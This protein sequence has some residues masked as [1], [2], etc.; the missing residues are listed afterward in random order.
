[1]KA[2]KAA[3]GASGVVLACAST[4]V[5]ALGFDL[6]DGDVTGH[7][8]TTAS[9]GAA[10]RMESQSK[11]LI[12]KG[13]MS[14][15]GCSGAYQTCQGL[16]RDQVYPS[17]Q[18]GRLPGAYAMRGDDGDL[19]Y[20]KHDLTQAVAKVT[21]DLTLNWGDF[22]F[23]GRW[24]YYYDFVNNDFDETHPNI[25]TPENV[26]RVGITGDPISNRYFSHVYGPG[27]REKLKRND[28]SSLRSIGTAFQ[29]LDANI[30][31]HVAIPFWE[32]HDL[33]F[34]IGRQTVNWGESTLLAINSINQANPVNANNLYRVGTQVEEVFTPV[35]MVFASIEPFTN[36]T[37]EAFYQFQWEPLD[38]PPPGSYFATN[39]LGTNNAGHSV[40][41]SFGSAPDDPE[42]AFDG[43]TAN[44]RKG[45]LDNPLTLITP[46]TGTLYRER[47]W[48]A[49]NQ[50]QFGIAMK[51]YAENLGSGTEFGAYF[52]NYH[53]K[54]PYISFFAAPTACSHNANVKNTTSFFAACG[55]IPAVADA[56]ARSQLGKDSIPLLTSNLLNPTL[57]RETGAL[58]VPD[59]LTTLN[60]LLISGGDPNA[61]LDDSAELDNPR[62]VFEYPENIH[63]FGLSF[64]TSIG[65][66]SI[67]GEVAYRPN[68]PLQISIA[69][70]GFAALGPTLQSCGNYV[71]GGC[72]GSSF[73]EGFAE[74]G[75]RV[76]YG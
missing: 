37:L 35:G 24:L 32:D 27:A 19:N 3:V 6:F 16:F 12:G 11:N 59:L 36:A 25:I 10:M 1:M 41:F 39:D 76:D 62:I 52:M 55:N 40:N 61:P 70:L 14:P 56:G 64:N 60:G 7:L 68:L 50:G 42:R 28:G 15:T 9:V 69:D 74:D 26:D 49:S 29:L 53:S 13:N 33:T 18:L 47:D 54:L 57:L 34:K 8:N 20:D 73:G 2:W 65:D 51:Y 58:N 21:Q 4:P 75:S 44:S 66:Y 63:L 5:F 22:G 67:Q 17:V 71:N 72:G 38:A 31:G 23:Y 46:T 45:Y 43:D 48:D 30:Y